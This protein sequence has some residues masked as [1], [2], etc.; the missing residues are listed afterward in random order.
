LYTV[1]VSLNTVGANKL[2][3][4]AGAS[5]FTFD[6][7]C[8]NSKQTK[9]FGDV[10]MQATP[11]APTV[12]ADKTTL[13]NQDVILTATFTD[14]P[15]I[16]QYKFGATGTWQ[17]YLGPVSAG[18]NGSYFFR[19]GD[20]LGNFSSET[21]YIVNNIDKEKPTKPYFTSTEPV[22]G[23]ITVS[24]NYSGDSIKKE[25]RI[26]ETGEWK[27]YTGGLVFTTNGD[28]IYARGIDEA[29][30][31]SDI[32]SYAVDILSNA[33]SLD[34]T[35]NNQKLAAYVTP[36][37]N[38]SAVIT[39]NTV[40]KGVPEFIL[41]CPTDSKV[42]YDNMKIRDRI[43]KDGDLEYTVTKTTAGIKI[44]ANSRVEGGLTK[45]FKVNF[46]VNKPTYNESGSYYTIQIKDTTSNIK[47]QVV[48]T[49]R[50]Y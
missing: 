45:S 38:F 23:S 24:I 22:D 10:M 33:T 11:K 44:R 39:Y 30:N 5:K 29:G 8:D 47:V 27:T 32:S 15:S 16:K 7:P 12:T 25:Y 31:I 13:T 21:E 26:G 19:G 18:A 50:I 35:L 17:T 3:S 37:G 2:I 49:K 20:G 43:I 46:L 41:V 9:N 4:K 28:V 48:R 42:L 36:K 40:G 14:N 34:F 6:D 1:P